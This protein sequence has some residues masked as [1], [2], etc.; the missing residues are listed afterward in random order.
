MYTGI[1]FLKER[2]R[3][4]E[5]TLLRDRKIAQITSIALGVF[6][7]VMIALLTYQFYLNTRLNAILASTSEEQR[8]LQGMTAKQNSYLSV[9]DKI[10]TVSSIFDLRGN[11][12]DAINFFYNLLPAG[13]AISSIDL[14]SVS[15]GSQL[16]FSLQTPS[17]FVYDQ[18]SAILQSDQVKKSGY[19][20]QLGSLSRSKDGTYR[21]EV[22]LNS[23]TAKP[24]ANL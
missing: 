12:W 8:R 1:N 2:T 7:F 11:K 16:S 3:I 19:V 14:E 9:Y 20:L 17:I 15:G 22:T 23:N 6:M 4:Q 24:A 13:T 21:L 10:K 5:L 18:L